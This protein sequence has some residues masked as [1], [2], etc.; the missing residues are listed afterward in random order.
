MPS[1]GISSTSG[2]KSIV[3]LEL[4]HALVALTARAELMKNESGKSIANDAQK[5]SKFG[6]N[7]YFSVMAATCPASS[8]CCGR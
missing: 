2:L 5:G 8:K 7:G 6:E 3:E 4:P 1:S